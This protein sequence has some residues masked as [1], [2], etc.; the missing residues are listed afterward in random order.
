MSVNLDDGEWCDLM[1]CHV[2][3][4]RSGDGLVQ[5]DL[6]YKNA[7][8]MTGAIKRAKA[9]DPDV[10]MILAVAPGRRTVCYKRDDSGVWRSC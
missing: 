8:D 5:F 4:V 3:A 10:R 6:A 2:V 1:A 9:L 7:P